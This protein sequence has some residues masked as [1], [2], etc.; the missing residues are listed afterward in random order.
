MEAKGFKLSKWAKDL[1]NSPDFTSCEKGKIYEIVILP[2]K[3]FLDGERTTK[4]ILAEGDKRGLSH[5]SELSTEVACLI[6]ENCSDEQIKKMGL[7]WLVTMHELIKDSV[8]ALFLLSTD[9]VRG[10]SWLSA[11]C[12]N[13]DRSWD[14]ENGFVFLAV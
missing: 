5:G 13:P 4:N 8:G 14:Y 7:N 11:R 9:W 6:R 10:A 3:L 2:G 12:G 1:L